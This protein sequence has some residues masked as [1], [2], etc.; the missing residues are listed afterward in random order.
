MTGFGILLRH[1]QASA[2]EKSMMFITLRGSLHFLCSN[3]RMLLTLFLKKSCL[4][5]KAPG[6]WMSCCRY[7]VSTLTTLAPERPYH[8]HYPT[9]MFRA[10]QPLNKRKSNPKE[11]KKSLSPLKRTKNTLPPCCRLPKCSK[12]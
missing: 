6:F 12:I 3:S 2:S 10:L 4:V 11:N 5:V 1:E 7:S 9:L 8:K